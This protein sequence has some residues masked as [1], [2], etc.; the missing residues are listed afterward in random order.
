MIQNSILQTLCFDFLIS[1]KLMMNVMLHTLKKFHDV[2]KNRKN[3]NG[4]MMLHLIEV[5]S[6]VTTV[7]EII[8][9]TR[10]MICFGNCF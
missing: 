2:I 9:Y 7:P 3:R 1:F 5:V 10:A 6:F 4:G 8:I